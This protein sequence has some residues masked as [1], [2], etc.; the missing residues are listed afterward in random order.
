M[1]YPKRILTV[2]PKVIDFGYFHV[3]YYFA[4]KI[5]VYCL[6]DK[7]LGFFCRASHQ[8]YKNLIFTSFPNKITSIG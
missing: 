8:K 5:I 6:E 2:V 7:I 4:A 1:V 3:V